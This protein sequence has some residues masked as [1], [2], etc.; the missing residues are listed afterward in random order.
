MEYER[1]CDANCSWCAW[2][3]FQKI[4]KGTRSVGERI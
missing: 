2:N 4:R 1:D 3:G